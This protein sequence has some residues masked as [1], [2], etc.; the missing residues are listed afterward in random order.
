[1]V[2]SSSSSKPVGFAVG[3]GCFILIGENLEVE[4]ELFLVGAKSDFKRSAR[5][6][7]IQIEPLAFITDR[8]LVNHRFYYHLF[9][10]LVLAFSYRYAKFDLF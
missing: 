4:A 10:V 3:R 6:T 5:E 7:F 8:L 9:G 2:L 1:M